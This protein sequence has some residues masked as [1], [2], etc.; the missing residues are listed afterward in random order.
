MR[1]LYAW[2]LSTRAGI[3]SNASDLCILPHLV[4]YEVVKGQQRA[5]EGGQ[6]D[7][8]HHVV[9]LHSKGACQLLHAQVRQQVED[10]MQT[11]V[12]HSHAFR[13]WAYFFGSMLG[14]HLGTSLPVRRLAL[15]GDHNRRQL[16]A[17]GKGALHGMSPQ[18]RPTS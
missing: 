17:P 7:G 3:S 10:I 12:F 9:G 15:P 2:A 5:R 13:S 18:I 6:V 1:V 4:V 16:R 11:P 14:V 8:Q